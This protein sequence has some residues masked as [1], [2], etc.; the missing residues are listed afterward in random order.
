MPF[1]MKQFMATQFVPRTEQV[2]LPGL[3][4]WFDEGE[5]PIWTVRGQTGA[6][7]AKVIEAGQHHKNLEEIV[8]A[9]SSTKEAAAEIKKIVG[10]DREVTPLDLIKRLE[11]L[12]QCSV[13]PKI[14]L[15]EAVFLAE[16]KPIEFFMLTNTITTLT[17]LGMDVKKSQGSGT[18]NEPEH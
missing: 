10:L 13:E 3:K 16:K 9:I 14:E 4:D 6:E 1:N 8:K 5:S 7:V 2:K 17:G 12:V 11:Q 18:T 15:N